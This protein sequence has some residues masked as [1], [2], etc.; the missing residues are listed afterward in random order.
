MRKTLAWILH[1]DEEHLNNVLLH[2]ITGVGNVSIGILLCAV[3]LTAIAVILTAI[4]AWGYIKYQGVEQGE[5]ND[6]CYPDI[7]GWLYGI[8]FASIGY[9]IVRL[10]YG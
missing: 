9:A 10:I 1:C 4:F 3:K 7:Q 8:A 2:M 5:I 6:R